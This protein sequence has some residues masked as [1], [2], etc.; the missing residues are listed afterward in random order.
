MLIKSLCCM[1]FNPVTNL[2]D[3]ITDAL[4]MTAT[5]TN[6]MFFVKAIKKKKNQPHAYCIVDISGELGAFLWALFVS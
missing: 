5:R 4:I 6:Y 3:I 2:V 1:H